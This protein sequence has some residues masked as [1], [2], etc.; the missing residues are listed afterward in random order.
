MNLSASQPVVVINEEEPKMARVF[1]FEIE[2]FLSGVTDGSTLFEALYGAV[3]DEP[4]PQRL[5]DLVRK[6]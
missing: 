1:S 3:V 5:L 4:I 6:A 2:C